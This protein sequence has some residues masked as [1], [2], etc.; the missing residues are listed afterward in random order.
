MYQYKEDLHNPEL[1][2][3]KRPM[4]NVTNHVQVKDPYEVQDRP[5]GYNMTEYAKSSLVFQFL[6]FQLTF[7]EVF[8]F[9]V[10]M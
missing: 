8:L 4:H 9:R 5:M 1:V 6:H 2:F 7:R 10:L 3:S